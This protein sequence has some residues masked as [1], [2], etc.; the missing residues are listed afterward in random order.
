MPN[1][2][3]RYCPVFSSP[4]GGNPKKT[5]GLVTAAPLGPSVYVGRLPRVAETLTKLAFTPP[6]DDMGLCLR[7]GG[8]Q[9]KTEPLERL[10]LRLIIRRSE[11]PGPVP[12]FGA[13]F[14]AEGLADDD[15]IGQSSA[16]PC[17]GPR[18]GEHTARNARLHPIFGPRPSPG[19][20]HVLLSTRMCSGCKEIACPWRKTDFAPA[21]PE[22][23]PRETS[24][25]H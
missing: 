19:C 12:F 7:H 15:R 9:S 1:V 20:Q 23:A 24:D 25:R 14:R 2:T 3:Y 8:A 22:A 13:D 18:K 10:P 4:E 17:S 11:H 16:L 21:I 6:R 5:G